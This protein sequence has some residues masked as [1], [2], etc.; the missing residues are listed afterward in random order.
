MSAPVAEWDAERV[1]NALRTI[2]RMRELRKRQANLLRELEET[3]AIGWL[4]CP[5]R[6]CKALRTKRCWVDSVGTGGDW[7]IHPMRMKMAR[8]TR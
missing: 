1:G 3:I 7:G 8:E 6:G 2:E 5:V 4:D